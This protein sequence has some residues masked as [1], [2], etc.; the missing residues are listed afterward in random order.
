MDKIMIDTCIGPVSTVYLKCVSVG[1]DVMAKYHLGV[2]CG[3]LAALLATGNITAMEH[4][5]LYNQYV[6]AE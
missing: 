3:F 2:I 1:D 6:L 5:A 4:M